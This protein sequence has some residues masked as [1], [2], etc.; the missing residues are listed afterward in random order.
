MLIAV[1]L[2]LALLAGVVSCATPEAI[3]L[4]PLLF[5]AAGAVN[6]ASLV[7]IAVGL[8]LSLVL[9]GTLTG[10]FGALF[11]YEGIWFRRIVCLLLLLQGIALIS[12][13]L[14]DR[15]PL[16][17]G[18]SDGGEADQ[19]MSDRRLI[20]R[21]MG[22][23]LL[24][25]ANWVPRAGPTLGKASLMAAGAQNLTLAFG[26]LFV[27][28]VGAALAW[29]AAGRIMRLVLW[30]V[31]RHASRGMAGKRL[32]GMTLMVVAIVGASGRDAELVH[33]LDLRLPAWTGKLA[34]TF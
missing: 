8:G 29:I 30:P 28:G 4:V 26:M 22:L 6:R 24:V 21:M 32:L 23:A 34:I 13:S 3:L 11:G 33:W 31:V 9:T 2:A 16:L 1:D 14:S 15:Y 5:G 25:G 27:F 20:F 19:E 7:A 17:T 12:G 18:G 10:S